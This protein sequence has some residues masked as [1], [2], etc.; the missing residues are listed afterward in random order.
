VLR[1]YRDDRGALERL[2][3][4]HGQKESGEEVLRP[5][6]STE[7][8][9]DPGALR[10]A[11]VDGR[12]QRV[13]SQPARL[14]YRL[15]P[16]TGQLAAELGQPRTLYRG[17][18]PEALALLV[19]VARSVRDQT[20]GRGALTVTSTVRDV[21]YQE[22][23]RTINDEAARGYSVHTTGYA[24]DVLRR[25]TAP[26]QARAFQFMLDRLQALGVIAWIREPQAIHVAVGPNAAPLVGTE[27]R[28]LATA[29][30]ETRS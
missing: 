18:R 11:W 20:G 14:G 10:A 4:A 1:L 2:A 8:F 19:Y 27:L 17:L 12:V 5:P 9:A 28:Q 15:D 25:Y 29:S 16:T 7:A 6:D 13:P 24:F 21:R 30:S 23:L 3:A 26:G 22:R